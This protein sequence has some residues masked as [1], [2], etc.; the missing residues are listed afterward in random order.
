[1]SVCTITLTSHSDAG[2]QTCE[3][4]PG[5]LGFEEIDAQTFAEWGVDC[6]TPITL[7]NYVLILN[8]TAKI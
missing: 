1:M 5:S 6:K 2:L 3:K 4:Y 7:L 8:D